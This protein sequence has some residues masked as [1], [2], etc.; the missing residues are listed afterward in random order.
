MLTDPVGTLWLNILF[1]IVVPFILY[2]WCCPPQEEKQN[3]D[4]VDQAE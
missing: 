3:G 4:H 2:I 1:V